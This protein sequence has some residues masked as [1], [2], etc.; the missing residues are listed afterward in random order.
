MPS[1]QKSDGTY[2]NMC[3]PATKEFSAQLQKAVVE[4]YV[5]TLTKEPV[6]KQ[7]AENN[8]KVAAYTAPPREK[9]AM[10]STERG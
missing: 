6:G 1:V 9:T 5:N 2:K 4:G 10:K 7:I 8:Q 3:F